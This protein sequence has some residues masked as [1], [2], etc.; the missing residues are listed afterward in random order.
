MTDKKTKVQTDPRI[1]PSEPDNNDATIY[2]ANEK[3]SGYRP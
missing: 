3:M 2:N 1:D